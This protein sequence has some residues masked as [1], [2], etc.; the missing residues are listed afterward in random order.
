MGMHTMSDISSLGQCRFRK[1]PACCPTQQEMRVNSVTC[2]RIF[3]NVFKFIVESGQ[4]GIEL[5]AQGLVLVLFL[6]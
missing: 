4:V 1:Y 6:V 2:L 5:L 3:Q